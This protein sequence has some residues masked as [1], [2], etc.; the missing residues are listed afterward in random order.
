MNAD[1]LSIV[2]RHNRRNINILALNGFV[3]QGRKHFAKQTSHNLHR[4][5]A[6]AKPAAPILWWKEKE[7]GRVFF[8]PHNKPS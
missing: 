5:T 7:P 3:C 6:G 8:S 1:E 4:I 2:A